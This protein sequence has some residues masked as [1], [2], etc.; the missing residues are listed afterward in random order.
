MI[1][2]V[3][4]WLKQI[5]KSLDFSLVFTDP[6]D[7]AKI[8]G[9][10]YAWIYAVDAERV[11]KDGQTIMTKNDQYFRHDYELR[12]RMGVRLALRDE[13]AATIA[14]EKFISSVAVA[15]N[16]LDTNGLDIEVAVLTAEFVSDKSLLKTGAG[17]DI[18]IE[19]TGGIYRAADAEQIDPWAAALSIWATA[20]LAGSWRSYAAYPVGKPDFSL[21][22]QVSGMEIEEKGLSH[23]MLRKRL[24]AK[25]YGPNDQ[26]AWAALQIVEALQQAFKVPLDAAS[27]KYMTVDRPEANLNRETNQV[28]VTLTRNISRPSEE[29]PL[30]KRIYTG[31]KLQEV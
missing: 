13:A 5:L 11:T 29:V 30:I 10:K 7:E 15:T 27:K 26:T 17:Y 6:E 21:Y 12:M 14:K 2:A 1:T 9:I 18:V 8:K 4:P 31:G 25:I 20:T 24:I 28:S 16:P 19:A 23:F 3:K 22:W